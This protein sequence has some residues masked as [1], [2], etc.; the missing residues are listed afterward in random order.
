MCA[1]NNLLLTQILAAHFALDLV[2]R[3]YNNLLITSIINLL[4][5]IQLILGDMLA[6]FE[7]AERQEKV[8][9][10]CKKKSNGWIEPWN[11]IIHILNILDLGMKKCDKLQNSHIISSEWGQRLYSA[12]QKC[13]S[14]GRKHIHST[15][16]RTLWFMSILVQTIPSV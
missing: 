3:H 2:F 11:C 13:P 8:G 16:C 1:I 5:F 7:S 6:F 9:E 10:I 15:M 12:L 14:I 4:I